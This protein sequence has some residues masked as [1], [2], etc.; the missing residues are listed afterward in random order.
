MANS[1]NN[2]EVSLKPPNA[3][4]LAD[5]LLLKQWTSFVYLHDVDSANRG[6]SIF[7]LPFLI[8]AE[9]HNFQRHRISV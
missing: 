1:L 4:L 7:P 8:W 6:K 2:F 5:L 3:Q 9:F